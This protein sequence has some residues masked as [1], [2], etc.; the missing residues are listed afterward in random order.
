MLTALLMF[1]SLSDQLRAWP[2]AAWVALALSYLLGSIPFGL[3]LARVVK[4]ID[5]RQVGS[6][7]IGA[8]NTARAMGRGWGI[9]VAVLDALKGYLPACCFP[10]F[11][12]LAPQA[13]LLAAALYG[14]AA[15]CGH[16]FPL[17]LAFRGGKGV[18]TAAG[19]M[20]GLDGRIFLAGGLVWLAALGATRYVGLASILM[21][22]TF[23]V[24]AY[25]W[26]TSEPAI[27]GL[28][29]L[30]FLLILIRHRTNLRRMLLGSEPRLGAKRTS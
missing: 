10:A 21:V 13:R 3:V 7:N 16:C 2:S 17:W 26:H 6:G 29:V 25:G 19:A 20:L 9:V 23:A 27:A 4:G 11:A 15:V 22:A 5:V 1:H 30:I 18:A 28:A 8:T 12:D 24:A 14:C